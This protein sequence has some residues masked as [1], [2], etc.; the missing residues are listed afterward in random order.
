MR[1]SPTLAF[2]LL[3]AGCTGT[4][5]PVADYPPA[6]ALRPAIAPKPAAP[7]PVAPHVAPTVPGP[8]GPLAQAGIGAYMD[9]LEIALRRHL[10]GTIVARQGDSIT[11]VI[12]NSMAFS[13]EGEVMGG[14][15]LDALSAVLRGYSHTVLQVGGFTD[16]AGPADRNLALTQQRARAFADALVRDGVAAGRVTAQ[17]FGETHLRVMTGDDKKEARNRR[18]EIAIKA[19]PG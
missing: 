10:R 14:G 11:V 18:L 4:P 8:A 19:K 6:P 16:T 17:G 7:Q 1:F 9:S 2:L 12:P 3:L 15:V 5:R 13:P